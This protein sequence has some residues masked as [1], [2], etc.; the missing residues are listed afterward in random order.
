MPVAV[1]AA[2]ILRRFRDKPWTLD[3]HNISATIKSLTAQAAKF[4]SGEYPNVDDG[5]KLDPPKPFVLLK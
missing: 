3:G 1:G 2:L 4:E 5:N